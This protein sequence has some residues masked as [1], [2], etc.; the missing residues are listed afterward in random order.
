MDRFLNSQRV[1][2]LELRGI[3]CR[4]SFCKDL[5]KKG[6]QRTG[7]SPSFS[8][9]VKAALPKQESLDFLAPRTPG[10]AK[11]SRSLRRR[12]AAGAYAPE[13]PLGL[14]LPSDRDPGHRRG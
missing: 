3:T 10:G 9:R 6:V 5:R 8:K 12:K 14:F 1:H 4:M 2:E 11:P 7:F 13:N